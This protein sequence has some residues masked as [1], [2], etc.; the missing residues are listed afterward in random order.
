MRAY[1]LQ[2]G[3]K[4]ALDVIIAGSRFGSF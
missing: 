4:A 2:V 1:I 3:P